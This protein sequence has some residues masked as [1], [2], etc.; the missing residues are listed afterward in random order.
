MNCY[1]AID[2]YCDAWE[3]ENLKIP[4]KTPSSTGDEFFI[5]LEIE[6]TYPSADEDMMV[7][8]EGADVF[9]FWAPCPRL[10]RKNLTKERISE[11]LTKARVPRHKQEFMIERISDRADEIANSARN[12][13][14]RVLPMK[15]S[16]SIVA[17]LC[18]GE[19]VED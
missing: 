12:K 19:S 17:C 10:E 1:E 8:V 6:T 9:S 7:E 13:E 5:A 14:R 18:Y 3:A 2:D 11:M 4:K 15:V 16:I